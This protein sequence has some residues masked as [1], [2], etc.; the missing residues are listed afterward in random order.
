[1]SERREQIFS[2]PL[3]SHNEHPREVW[4]GKLTSALVRYNPFD[5]QE[6]IIEALQDKKFSPNPKTFAKKTAQLMILMT[7]KQA[8]PHGVHDGPASIALRKICDVLEDFVKTAGFM[9]SGSRE[10]LLSDIRALD[11]RH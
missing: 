6:L 3:P 9:N 5:V 7:G 10:K 4:E 8:D 11:L 2:D 1:M